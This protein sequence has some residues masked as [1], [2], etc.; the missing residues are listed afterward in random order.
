MK[1]W[2]KSSRWN[3]GPTLIAWRH[4]DVKRYISRIFFTWLLGA[5]VF[6]LLTSIFF[7]TIG[8]DHLS[9]PLARIVFFVIFIYGLVTDLFRYVIR[10]LNYQVCRDGMVYV[11]PY[12]GWEPGSGTH[13]SQEKETVP[14][15]YFYIPWQDVKDIQEDE[16]HMLLTVKDKKE[17]VELAIPVKPVIK[18]SMHLDKQ[19]S[20]QHFTSKTKTEKEK[21]EFQKEIM[22][23]VLQT[24]RQARKNAVSPD[25]K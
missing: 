8:Q 15:R 1:I 22:R 24:A 18:A 23:S 6:G 17:D 21:A 7:L 14:S 16:E 13:F 11:K 19:G 9:L 12:I 20:I 5:F 10:G 2:K 4:Q 25:S 3:F